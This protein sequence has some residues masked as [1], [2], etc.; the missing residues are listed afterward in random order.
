VPESATRS[1]EVFEVAAPGSRK[2]PGKLRKNKDKKM[3]MNTDVF[4]KGIVQ[5]FDETKGFGFILSG[6][7]SI[8]VHRKNV[9]QKPCFDTLIRGEEVEYQIG[10]HRDR[11]TAINV[12]RL[13]TVIC[14][15]SEPAPAAA[16][17]SFDERN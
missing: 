15:T 16:G 1:S 6:A 9:I 2:V 11:P 8:F 3:N 7:E 13:N 14:G 12:R 4:Y 10:F 17:S 5:W